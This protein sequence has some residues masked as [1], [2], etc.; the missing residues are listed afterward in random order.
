MNKTATLLR[1]NLRYNRTMSIVRAMMDI[2]HPRLRDGVDLQ[3]VHDDLIRLLNDAGAEI[4]TDHDRRE[5]G[6]QPRDGY[7][8]TPDELIALDRHRLEIMTRP[9]GPIIVSIPDL[10]GPP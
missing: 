3:D 5:A 4:L 1:T 2:V 6:L 7:G 9:L 8:W 10:D